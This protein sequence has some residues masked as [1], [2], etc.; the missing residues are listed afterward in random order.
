MPDQHLREMLE[1]L[2]A[3]L[4]QAG[5]VDERSRDLLRNVM[6]DI[7]EVLE[8][9][10]AEAH[11]ESLVTRLREAVDEFEESHPALTEAVGRVVDALAKMG[12]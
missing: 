8:P 10:A 1:Q 12:I 6:A 7:H 4:Q 9:S 11:P 2:H 3:E 5:S